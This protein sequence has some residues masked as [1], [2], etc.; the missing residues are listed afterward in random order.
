[1]QLSSHGTVK[2]Y[3]VIAHY[4]NHP[5]HVHNGEQYGSGCI[6][7]WLPIVP[8]LA[9]EEGKTGYANFKHLLKKVVE[10]SKVGYLHGCYNKV[11]C[12]LFP[13]VLILSADY[14]ELALALFEEKKMVSEKKLKSPRLHP[15]KNAFWSVEHLEPE[16]AASFEPLHSLHGGMGGKHI[17]GELRIVISELGCDSETCLEAQ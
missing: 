4:V 8:E 7:G 1:M 5:V 16:Q 10:L 13:L 14:E 3:P 9:K 2:G 15:V 11:L 12:W 17:H 6:I